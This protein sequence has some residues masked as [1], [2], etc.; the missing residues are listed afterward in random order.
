MSLFDFFSGDTIKIDMT[1]A[2]PKRFRRVDLTGGEVADN[3]KLYGLYKGTDYKTQF[4]SGYANTPIAVPTSFVGIPTPIVDDE[5]T[6][7]ACQ[8]ITDKFKDEFSIIERTKLL[9]G[10]AWRFAKFDRRSNSVIWEIIPDNT[11]EAVEI[12]VSSGEIIAINTSESIEVYVNNIQK[13]LV[14]RERRFS[15]DYIT[16]KYVSK[17]GYNKPVE[18]TKVRNIF[19]N[20]PVPFGH[21]CL[22][23]EWRGLSVFARAYR[24]M[25]ATHDI[26]NKR[27]Q[28]LS[29]FGP[30][31]VLTVEK[32]K[33][34]EWLENNGYADNELP[35]PFADD[36]WMNQGQIEKTEYLH[37]PAGA[38]DQHTKAIEDNRKEIIIATGIPELYWPPLATGNHA[39]TENQKDLAIQYIKELRRENEK[40]Y[41][42]LFNDTLRIMGFIEMRNYQ[43]VKISWNNFDMLSMDARASVFDKFMSG[44]SK[45]ISNAIMGHEEL[46]Y[47]VKE[48]FPDIPEKTIDEFK[49]GQYGM[50][51]LASIVKGDFLTSLDSNE[52][53]P[54]DK[55]DET[56]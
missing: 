53:T 11:I 46:Y 23:G 9:L 7:E 10:T 21:D 52:F 8:I 43:P 40:S 34:K 35:D 19:G 41:E 56:V 31:L 51:K 50:A 17:G 12:D 18:D 45:L 49:T 25:R 47:F 48:F 38:T 3:D 33:G 36:F 37:L 42:T 20:M 22:E 24:I 26:K 6:K 15:R 32:A 4:V 30:K 54:E 14:Q 28:I 44:A 16:T 5:P 27:E 55:K 1:K 13:T 2:S 39:S 29:Q